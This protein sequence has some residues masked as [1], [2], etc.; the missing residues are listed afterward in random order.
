[1]IYKNSGNSSPLRPEV[2][3]IYTAL[4]FQSLSDMEYETANGLNCCSSSIALRTIAINQFSWTDIL[5]LLGYHMDPD[6]CFC[7]LRLV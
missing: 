4:L 6:A 2:V 1:M 7:R 5:V 3:K